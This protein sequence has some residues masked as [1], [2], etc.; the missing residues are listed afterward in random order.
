MNTMNMIKAHFDVTNGAKKS[1]VAKEH[2]VGAST[3]TRWMEKVELARVKAH[4]QKLEM[5][6]AIKYFQIKKQYELV[7]SK[8]QKKNKYE[9]INPNPTKNADFRAEL[10]K[11]K[12]KNKPTGTLALAFSKVGM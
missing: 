10:M 12:E 3:I 8:N 11:K 6:R 5:E 2:G 1:E 9:F 7:T 4:E